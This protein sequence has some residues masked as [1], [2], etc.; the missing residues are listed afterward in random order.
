MGKGRIKAFGN[1]WWNS[2]KIVEFWGGDGD[3]IFGELTNSTLIV[4]IGNLNLEL[5]Y[6]KVL[7]FKNDEIFEGNTTNNQ[8]EDDFYINLLN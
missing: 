6:S 1:L 2:P 7:F 8:C 5:W 4:L 3:K